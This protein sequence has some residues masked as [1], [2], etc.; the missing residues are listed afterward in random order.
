[1]LCCADLTSQH[2]TDAARDRQG[3]HSQAPVYAADHRLVV[4]EA[5]NMDPE[6]YEGDMVASSNFGTSSPYSRC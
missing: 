6:G 3:G 1:M 4:M 5:P 2:G